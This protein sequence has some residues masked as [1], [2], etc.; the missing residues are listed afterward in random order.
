[1][2]VLDTNVVSELMRDQPEPGVLAW[3]DSR[4]S[5]DLFVTAVTEAEIRVGIV[6]M[7][8]G[9]RRGELEAAAARVLESFFAG[10]VLPLDWQAARQY[11][12]I[13]SERNAAG[14][15]I[16]AFDG[17]IAATARARGAAIATRDVRGFEGLGIE[18]VNPWEGS[19]AVPR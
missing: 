14:R 12:A 17:L 1:M 15:P 2:I 11:A 19:D 13:V 6:T 10:R 8:M 9:R 18:L 5:N 3:V 4:T 16:G 7:P